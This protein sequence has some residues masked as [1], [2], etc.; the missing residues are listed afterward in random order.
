MPI[1]H[2]VHAENKSYME[3][4]Q[5]AWQRDGKCHPQRHIGQQ[6]SD[7]QH[8][9]QQQRLVSHAGE[10]APQSG[11]W[12]GAVRHDDEAQYDGAELELGAGEGTASGAAD[13]GGGLPGI[14]A[15]GGEPDSR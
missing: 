11:C 9:E 1:P 15:V 12:V 13:A 14:A 5:P 3:H 6:E 10:S 4:Q 2:E 8:A 7:R